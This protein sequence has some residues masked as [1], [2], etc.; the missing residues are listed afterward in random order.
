MSR[1]AALRLGAALG[2]FAYR[3]TPRY[4]K[5]AM[6]NLTEVYGDTWSKERIETVARDV[7]RH[8]GMTMVE[9]VRLPSTTSAD[10][11]KIV[12]VNGEENMIEGLARGKGVLALTAHVG[13]FEMMAAACA[14]RGYTISVI[15]RDADDAQMNE[16]INAIRES[17]G[18][19]VLPRKVAA[20]K[21]ITALRRNEL[22]GVL[23]D[24][25]NNRGIFVPFMGRLAA[26]SPGP[27]FIALHSDAAILPI[28][29]H[30]DSDNNH[31]IDVYPELNVKRTGDRDLDL[32]ELTYQMHSAIERAVRAHP[33]QWFWLHRRW[34]HRP[35]PE[36]EALWKET[37]DPLAAFR[38]GQGLEPVRTHT[39][40]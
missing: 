22:V 35:T 37:G 5:A 4:R 10:L 33:D 18:Y 15:A 7:F 6:E 27:A 29:V 8:L 17:K 2:A 31:T 39:D 1:D 13:N 30:R 24:Q 21:S 16:V 12:R 19:T 23:P 36:I 34:K 26:S 3:V 20:R 9:F 38:T 14:A 40:G 11:M 28:F 32:Y 25:N